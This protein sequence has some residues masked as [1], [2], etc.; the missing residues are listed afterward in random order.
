MG[1]E[2]NILTIIEMVD[3]L[4]DNLIAFV[5]EHRGRRPFAIDADNGARDAIWSR[6]N[7]T[8]FPFEGF[9]RCFCCRCEQNECWN[10]PTHGEDDRRDE[11][12]TDTWQQRELY[13][14]EDIADMGWLKL[15]TV[16]PLS[17]LDQL[18]A[19]PVGSPG[20][21][22]IPSGLDKAWIL[23]LRQRALPRAR[24]TNQPSGLST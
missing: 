2:G 7:I 16:P 18:T 4:N 3:Y 14:E 9:C 11:K 5:D 6:S 1:V 10:T 22:D 8:H 19:K 23:K 17:S 21:A 15:A 24:L 13:L 12:H 20:D